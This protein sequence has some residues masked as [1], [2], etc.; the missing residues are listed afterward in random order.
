MEEVK[1]ILSKDSANRTQY[2]AKGEKTFDLYGRG[3]AYFIQR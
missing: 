1:T 2:K 3:E